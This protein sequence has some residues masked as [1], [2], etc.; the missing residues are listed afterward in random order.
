MGGEGKQE[1]ETPEEI[2]KRAAQKEV[3]VSSGASRISPQKAKE[4]RQKIKGM[5]LSLQ[6]ATFD[7]PSEK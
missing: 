2:I 3:T 4:L 7:K 5:D 1:I 6:K